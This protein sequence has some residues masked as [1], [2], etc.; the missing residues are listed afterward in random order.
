M[1][2]FTDNKGRKWEVEINVAVVNRVK[3][4]IDVDMLDTEGGRFIER[5]STDPCLLCNVLYCCVHPQATAGDVSDEDFGE[6]LGGDA[7][8]HATDALLKAYVDFFPSR[9]G[10]VMAKALAKVK[11]IENK[12]ID[13]AHLRIDDPSFDENI[14]KALESKLGGMPSTSSPEP[15]A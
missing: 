7:I 8:E 13:M 14:E 1:H 11:Q 9:K 4:M 10:Q 2:A 15:S 5:I 3:R 6:A 12:A